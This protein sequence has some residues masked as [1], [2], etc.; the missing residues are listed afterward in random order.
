MTRC[1]G[2]G[3]E[4]DAHM[5]QCWE[6]H[7]TLGSGSSEPEGLDDDFDDEDDDLLDLEKDDEDLDID[8]AP[9]AR[10]RP[11]PGK[12][13]LENAADALLAEDTAD[14]DDDDDGD[15]QVPDSAVVAYVAQDEVQAGA[16]S[17]LL[18]DC[19]IRN[20]ATSHGEEDS[21]TS[22]E[23]TMQVQVLKEDL[24]AARQV[25]ADFTSE[26]DDFA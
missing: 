16:I 18:S 11:A 19:G 23:S 1:P 25:I 3:A 24:A 6:C 13:D 7:E 21:D 26:F 2:C 20:F 17:Q 22:A 14:S 5:T 12:A 15:L 10:K 8:P 4:I 9:K